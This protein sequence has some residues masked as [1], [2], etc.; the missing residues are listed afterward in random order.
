M[1]GSRLLFPIKVLPEVSVAAEVLGRPAGFPFTNSILMTI[2]VDILLMLLVIMATRKMAL[3][4]RG[5]QNL[6]ELAVETF[7]GLGES[8]DRRN[9]RRMFTLTAT[10]F[11]FVL[12]ANMLA[13]VPGV[14][15]VGMC[16]AREAALIN[17]PAAQSTNEPPVAALTQD[18]IN[19]DVGASGGACG[20]YQTAD[21]RTEVAT[22]VP[23]FRSP[24]ADLNTTLAIALIS[25]FAIEY[26]GFK[27]LGIGYLGKFFNI[28]E[29][30]YIAL[31]GIL[32]LISEF[33]RIMSFTF[34]L[35]GNIFA[36]EVVL[37]VMAFLVPWL[38]P[39][40]FYGLEIFVAF[41]QA[42]IFAILTIA[43][44]NQATTAHH[45]ADAHGGH[46]EASPVDAAH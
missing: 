42:F 35:F 40:P 30:P 7:Y 20:T 13:L 44:I 25:F 4:P 41:M 29:G 38:L 9:I 21:G 39:L 36:G 19:H 37:A 26:F 43:F 28:K 31:V 16:R 45:E 8:V 14:G 46:V 5:A 11:T 10:I 17:P 2:V 32:E 22:L 3:V 18:E 33:V 24:S 27:D 12:F 15:S 23:F 6:W 1:I 34:R